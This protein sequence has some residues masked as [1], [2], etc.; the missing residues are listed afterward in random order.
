MMVIDPLGIWLIVLK[1]PRPFLRVKKGKTTK[2]PFIQPGA[3]NSHVSPQFFWIKPVSL[4]LPTRPSPYM[5][6]KQVYGN[7]HSK[8]R[9]F[10]GLQ[11][12]SS[13]KNNCHLPGLIH[14]PAPEAT[15]NPPMRRSSPGRST[16]FSERAFASLASSSAILATSSSTC[17]RSWG[18][19]DEHV[20]SQTSTSKTGEE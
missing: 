17:F 14:P 3:L 11:K 8:H 15:N 13:Q 16:C 12:P 4:W 18:I 10:E 7:Q 20:N 5:A 1:N 2:C 9:K 6:T 19:S